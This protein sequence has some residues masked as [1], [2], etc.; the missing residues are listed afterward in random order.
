MLNDLLSRLTLGSWA[1]LAE[2]QRE[3]IGGFTVDVLGLEGTSWGTFGIF[4]GWTS[5]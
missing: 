4:R 5:V 1:W 2:V 3:L